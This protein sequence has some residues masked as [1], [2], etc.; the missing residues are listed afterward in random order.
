MVVDGD[1]LS[2]PVRLLP[3]KLSRGVS[4]TWGGS[5]IL[6]FG[7]PDSRNIIGILSIMWRVE[8]I[9]A[10]TKDQILFAGLYLVYG[11]F[12]ILTKGS[13]HS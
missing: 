9:A 12:Q 7:P 6:L 8:Y 2:L 5:S 1:A 13:R 4:L 3:P 10:I 11:Y